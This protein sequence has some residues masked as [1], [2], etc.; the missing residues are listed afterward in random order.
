MKCIHHNDSDGRYA[1][2]IVG[3]FF[4]ESLEIDDFIELDYSNDIPYEKFK[5]DEL[6]YIVD[7]S[8]GPDEIDKLFDL[9]RITTNI[10]WIDHHASSL[11][12]IGKFPEIKEQI[13]TKIEVGRCAAMLVYEYF[14][15][16]ANHKV[17]MPRVLELLDDYDCWKKQFDS[18]NA[19]N[20]GLMGLE[21]VHPLA[22][23]Y[24]RLLDPDNYKVLD[25]II[26]T[27]KVIEQY[28][29]AA[30]KDYISK[31]G[32]D[33]K[34]KSTDKEYK[35]CVVNTRSNSLIFGDK[36]KDYDLVCCYWSTNKE[37]YQYSIFTVND[38][39]RCDKIAEEFG[40]GGHARAAGFVLDYK[41]F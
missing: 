32:Y 36:I 4:N 10:V 8:F 29:L 33:A 38:N 14:N 13:F 41:L 24:E 23:L 22:I 5:R 9:M 27:G 25:S 37:S 30:N 39:I 2:A 31:Y 21:D 7:Y 35:I 16:S 19:L 6:V 11:K 17:K 18:S 34:L 20:Y 15:I 28:M 12:S 3:I 1:A 26:R 40:G